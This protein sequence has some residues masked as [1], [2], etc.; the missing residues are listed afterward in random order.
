MKKIAVVAAVLAVLSVPDVAAAQKKGQLTPMQLQAMQQKEFDAPKPTVFSSVM[1]VFQDLGYSVGSA[2]MNTGFIT[3]ESA[4][5]NRTSFWEALGDMSSSGNTRATA[6][7]EQMPSGMS[8]VRLNFVSTKSMSGAYGWNTR[9]D[10]PIQDPA[11]YQR[12][13]EKVDE[14][15]F[16]RRAVAAP[17]PAAP[18]PPA[19][20]EVEAN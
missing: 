11:V 1:D 19:P 3:A 6:F 12:A 16:V 17:A 4:T 9:R 13:F 10:Q 5:T 18:S 2:D 15:L 8:R 7:I 20:A 14:A